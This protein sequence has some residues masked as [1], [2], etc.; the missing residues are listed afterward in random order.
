MSRPRSERQISLANREIVRNI[1]EIL[2][3]RWEGSCSWTL[4]WHYCCSSSLK[5]NCAF[6]NAT[7]FSCAFCR[8]Q[9][10]AV[11]CTGNSFSQHPETKCHWAVTNLPAAE[12][13]KVPQVCL[14]HLCALVKP[15]LK[16]SHNTGREA[17]IIKT[18]IIFNI[19]TH[20]SLQTGFI[21]SQSE[22]T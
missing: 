19:S 11:D 10:S 16:P 18:Q 20:F 7:T 12:G 4:Q 8:K 22:G 17:G 14:S 13:G 21:I 3:G 6:R 1:K 2:R 15:V 5:C 9:N